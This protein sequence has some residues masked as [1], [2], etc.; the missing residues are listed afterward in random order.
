MFFTKFLKNKLFPDEISDSVFAIDYDK[1]L[2][3]GIKGL[4]FDIDNTLATFDIPSP[5][6]RIV[7]L[8]DNLQKKGFKIALL[9]NNSAARVK[10]FSQ[11]LGLCHIWNAKKPSTKGLAQ[12]AKHISLPKKQI[13]IIGDQIFTDCFCGRRYGIYTILTKPIAA[14]DEWT[15]KLKRLPEKF[16]LKAYKKH[17]RDKQ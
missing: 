5:P 7:G 4:I 14:R 8:L 12:A 16:V 6:K 9:S 11:N 2:Q 10:K 15:V 13:A 17:N 1:L 3:M